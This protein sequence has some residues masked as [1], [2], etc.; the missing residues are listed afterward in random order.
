MPWM[1]RGL[2]ACIVLQLVVDLVALATAWP[3]AT[4]SVRGSAVLGL[5]LDV[6]LLLALAHGSD[7]VRGLVRIGATIGLTIDVVLLVQWWT[8]ARADTTSGVL[9]IALVIGSAFAVWVLGHR[10]VQAW[11]FARWAA[12][13][14]L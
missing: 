6:A 3:D 8:F 2:V 1:M 12:K 7:R 10:D 13:H 4:A 11:S 14:G 9:A 5:L